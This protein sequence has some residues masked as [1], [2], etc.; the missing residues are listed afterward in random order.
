MKKIFFILACL[1]YTLSSCLPNEA[2]TDKFIRLNQSLEYAIDGMREDS[3]NA[4]I[5][6]KKEVERS[7]NYPEGLSSI[8]RAEELKQ[9]TAKIFGE[10]Q[11]IKR[12]L[13]EHD[14]TKNPAQHTSVEKILIGTNKNGR[15]YALK[16]SL[17]AHIQYLNKEFVADKS[18]SFNREFEGL[19]KEDKYKRDFVQAN[20]GQASLI[21]SIA[22][23]TQIQTD[24]IRYEQE[25]LKKLSPAFCG[26]EIKFDRILPMVSAESNIVEVGKDYKAQLFIIATTNKAGVRMTYNGQ[27]IKVNDN[28]VG[29]VS[30]TATGKGKQVWVGTITAN[31]RGKDSTFTIQKE[32]EVIEPIE[33]K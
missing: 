1:A 26:R 11:A 6:I 21:A 25:V 32:Y 3:E 17:D 23:L 2:D 4:L 16:N 28:G 12:E 27:A 15:G 24:I 19:A 30:F 8:K 5:L 33:R 14:E 18:L 10:I 31:I 13:F 20:F 29:K 7:G 9:S 22:L